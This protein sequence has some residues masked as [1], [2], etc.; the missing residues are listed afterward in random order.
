MSTDLIDPQKHH[1]LFLDSRALISE[2]G[3]TRTLHP[4]K[5]CGPLI[6]GGIQSRSA[7]LWNPDE[8]RYE[9]WYNGP[10][11]RFAISHDGEHW[12]KPSLGL[13]ESDGNKDNNIAC[14]PNGP[15]L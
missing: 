7:P 3:T 14:D 10:Q 15:G 2:Q 1:Q 11:A 13:Y 4:P 12:E 5:K 8:E 9:W 6:T